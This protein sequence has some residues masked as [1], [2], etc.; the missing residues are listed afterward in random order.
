MKNNKI[1]NKK[2][3]ISFV[4]LIV[5]F[6]LCIVFIINR[7]KYSLFYENGHFRNIDYGC[8]FNQLNLKLKE[9]TGNYIDKKEKKEYIQNFDGIKGLNATVEYGCTDDWY[10]GVLII[11]D[12]ND[13]Y[14]IDDVYNIFY[15]RFCKLYG[16]PIE[17]HKWITE[18]TNIDLYTFSYING[19]EQVGIWIVSSEYL[20]K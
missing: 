3:L 4:I 2:F 6:I 20:K 18:D 11:F 15:K 16:D 13:N 17:K 10:D 1:I 5:S 12:K 8:T 19:Y 9:L 14:S 7:N